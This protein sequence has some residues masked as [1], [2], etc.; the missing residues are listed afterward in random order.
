MEPV[1]RN[2]KIVASTLEPKSF[3]E[4]QA[5]VDAIIARE[6]TIKDDAKAE[7]ERLKNGRS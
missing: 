2:T 3:E 4:L 7:A 1:T 5:V 6:S